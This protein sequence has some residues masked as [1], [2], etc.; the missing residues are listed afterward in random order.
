VVFSR[1]GISYRYA[2]DSDIIFS[3]FIDWALTE[4]IENGDCNGEQNLEEVATHEIGHLFGMA[5]SCEET[6][7]QQ[8]LCDDN[9]LLDAVM[10]WTASGSCTLEQELETDDI[11]GMNALYGPYASFTPSDNVHGGVPLEVCFEPFVDEGASDNLGAEIT[12]VEWLFGDGQSSTDTSICHTYEEKGQYT[13]QS[14][15]T[16]T[17]DSCGE[18]SYTNRSRALVVACEE[19]RPA[20]GLT[21]LFEYERAADFDDEETGELV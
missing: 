2:E 7:V 5:H 16:G 13:V 1:G 12:G 21:E 17:S 11:E 19:P 4:D 8:G 10:F 9:A 3:E 18:W 14:V 20:V 6:D 15:I